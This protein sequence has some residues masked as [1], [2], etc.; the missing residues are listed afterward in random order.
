MPLF[1]EEH[2]H[3]ELEGVRDIQPYSPVVFHPFLRVL[4]SIVLFTVLAMISFFAQLY[5]VKAFIFITFELFHQNVQLDSS[6]ILHTS[7]QI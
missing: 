5:D 1:Q 6:S 7:A 4:H 2:H 3:R